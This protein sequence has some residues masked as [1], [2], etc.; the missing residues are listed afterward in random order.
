MTITPDTY[1]TV[2]KAFETISHDRGSQAGWPSYHIPDSKVSPESLRQ[3][4]HALAHLTEADLDEFCTG[5]YGTML[6]IALVR[7]S[8]Q[9]IIYLM[10]FS[11]NGA[12]DDQT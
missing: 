6:A 4:E 2:Y 8:N 1:P 3:I 5:E 10:H 7:H 12:V 9:P 11:T